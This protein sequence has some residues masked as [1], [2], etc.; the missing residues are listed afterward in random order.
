MDIDTRLLRYFAAVVEEGNLTRAAERLYVSQPALTKQIRRLEAQLGTALFVRSRTG[1]TPTEAGEALAAH[2]GAVLTAWDGALRITRVATARASRT[3]RVGFV[4]S[5]ANEHTQPI[6]ADFARRRPG[7]RV[8]MRQAEWTDPTA[9][10]AT[11]EADVALLRLP[12]PA[13][14]D[15]NIEVLLTEPRWIALPAGHHLA[16]EDRVRFEDVYDEP[17]VATPATSG[18]WRNYWLATDER[19]G[20]PVL[21]GAVAHHPDEWLNA[22]AHGQGISLT[23]EATARFYQRPDVVYR[24]VTGVSPSQIAVAWPRTQ[25]VDDTVDAFVLSCRAVCNNSHLAHTRPASQNLT[26][27]RI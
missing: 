10:L 17:F 22:I 16:A 3:L 21:I 27:H 19:G 23:P 6:M 24:P 14:S 1:M 12:L 8:Q 7:W 2:A 5:A 15:F 20:H 25:P 4:A 11:G 18:T 26:D 9:G 13:Q